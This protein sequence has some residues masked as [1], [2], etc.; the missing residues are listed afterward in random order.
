MWVHLG[1]ERRRG[2]SVAALKWQLGPNA[3]RKEVGPKGSGTQ[4]KRESQ[5]DETLILHGTR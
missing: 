3:P 5:I 4:R 1:L 2:I